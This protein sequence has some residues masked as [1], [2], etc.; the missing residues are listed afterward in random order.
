MSTSVSVIVNSITG[1]M[2]CETIRAIM[3][4]AD[5]DLTAG[6][7]SRVSLNPMSASELP[8]SSRILSDTRKEMPEVT[9][10]SSLDDALAHVTADVYVDF[11]MASLAIVSIARA[12]ESN[13]SVVTGTTGIADDVLISL[14]NLA[15]T[16]GVCLIYAPNFSIGAVVLEKAAKLASKYFS[17]SEIIEYHHA[18]KADAPSGTAI[19]T[20]KI[21]ADE[22]RGGSGSFDSSDESGVDARD[23][24]T[25]GHVVKGT[26]IHSIRLP[27]F[28]AHQ[29][30]L[31]GGTDEVLTFR[32]DAHNRRCYM[33]GVVLAIRKAIHCRGLVYGLE[34][35]LD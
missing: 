6:I 19:H 15:Q 13:M 34:K 9:A 16:L 3:S 2:G 12:L 21:I 1:K 14:G 29:E 4:E 27:G 8:V 25:R 18:T 28:T 7:S 20:A 24:A 32:H 33:P 17:K 35:L 10:F 26:R 31:F 11:T 23:T 5:L 22:S 30:V